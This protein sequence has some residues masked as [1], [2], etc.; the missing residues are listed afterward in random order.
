MPSTE[1][2]PHMCRDGHVEIRH[3]L[4]DE[5]EW[6]P[7]CHAMHA[8]ADLVMLCKRHGLDATAEYNGAWTALARV[9]DRE[10]LEY[11]RQNLDALLERIT[12]ENRHDET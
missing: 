9:A 3:G 8:L 12:P 11:R 2:T 6:C 1:L 10:E 7:L 5:W 4:S